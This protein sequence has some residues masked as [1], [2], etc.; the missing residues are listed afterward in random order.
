MGAP[1][2]SRV[3]GEDD[4]QRGGEDDDDRRDEDHAEDHLLEN[5]RRPHRPATARRRCPRQRLFISR[6]TTHLAP[7]GL[8]AKPPTRRSRGRTS[9]LC[10]HRRGASTSREMQVP[11]RFGCGRATDDAGK[12]MR[13]SMLWLWVRGRHRARMLAVF[14]AILIGG[15]HRAQARGWCR[16]SGWPTNA[17]L[18]A[19]RLAKSAVLT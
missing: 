16:R 13:N 10:P 1:A 5:D 7:G 15:G 6:R 19:D 2:P 4:M 17:D 14:D 3:A 12:M 11:V 18:P 9:V 8:G